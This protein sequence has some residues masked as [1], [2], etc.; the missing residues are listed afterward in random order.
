MNARARRLAPY[1]LL[2]LAVMAAYGNIFA[3]GFVFDD[4]LLVTRNALLRHWDTFGKL[5]VEGTTGGAHVP[6]GFYRP[7]QDILFF[8]IYQIFGPSPFGFHLADIALH[9]ANAGLVYV[10][11][12]RLKF[13]PA[14]AFAGALIWA[15]HP[16]H[17]E[18]VTF[19]SSMADPL[20]TLLC[21]VGLLIVLPDAS[22]RRC[23]YAVPVFLLA[24]LSKESA[25][26]FPALIVV[27]LYL[28][29][30]ARLRPK[31]YL[32]TWPLWLVEVAYVIVRFTVLRSYGFQDF[33]RPE[34]HYLQLYATH[35]SYRI[36]TA[37]A[38]LPCYL[39]VL[40]WPVG[41]H[42]ERDFPVYLDPFHWQVAVGAAMVAGAVAQIIW[43]RGRRGLALSWG[44]L[45]FAVA[46]APNSGILVPTDALFLE[47]WMYVPT[48][49]LF[50]GLAESLAAWIE[51]QQAAEK[52]RRGAAIIVCIAALVLGVRTIDQ[53][54]VWRNSFTLYA[55]LFSFGHGSA[56]AHNNLGVAYAEIKK[57][58]E[59]VAQFREAIRI[60][61]TLAESH[62]NLG[63]ALL[64]LPDQK[65]H[66]AEAVAQLKRA[67]AM[68]PELYQP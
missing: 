1:A 6:G 35:L 10:L 68:N 61:D 50:L 4:G 52:L 48:I 45:W 67:I 17:T 27:C 62:L 40:L 38:V 3:N 47:H 32:P 42:M 55:W 59:A 22:L 54:M 58:P 23:L 20:C 37:L 15:L 49:G 19:I 2:A 46:Q 18:A 34:Y 25:A 43:G 31:T 24:L 33:S 5:L 9:A 26:V 57:Y 12:V 16:I 8:F 60:S 28:V 11:G 63:V 41:L 64:D 44:F 51:R 13:R 29:S 36:Y 39:G 53:N 14:A 30:P 66:M 56:R 21:L 7:V 65:A